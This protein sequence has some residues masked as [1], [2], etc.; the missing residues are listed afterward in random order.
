MTVDLAQL[1]QI[2]T[3]A[4]LHELGDEVDLVFRYGSFL[5]GNTHAYSDLDISYVPVHE[6]TGHHITVTVDDM[7][8]DLYPIRWSQLESMARFEN[9]SSTVLLTYQVI[10]QRSDTS[11]K[12]LHQL[13][14]QLR[15]S[16]Q[17]AARQ[18]MIGKAQAYF[19]RAGYSFYLLHQQAALENQLACLQQAQGIVST[20]AHSLAIVNQR[21]VDTR[22]PDQ[23]LALP[24]LPDDF[25]TTIAWVTS[26]I[27]PDELLAAC[28]ELLNSTHALLLSEQRQYSDHN[29]TYRAAF[30]AGYPELKGDLQHILLACERQD[31]F[32]LKRLL[33]SLY[34]ELSLAMTKAETGISYNNF[35]SLA[36]YEQD[37]VG[38]GFPPLLSYLETADFDELHRQTLAFDE[39]LQRFLV[40]H[41]AVLYSFAS[42]AELERYLASDNS[43]T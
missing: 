26:A 24:K 36:D 19:Q 13:A 10:Y 1:T 32:S 39:H 41:G 25:A 16:L 7:L 23:I 22:K 34:H 30:G 18:T 43:E 37:F 20:V 40:E 28:E 6:S 27:D 12:R 11:A 31:R 17:P 35:S 8:C 9:I 14:D 33:V 5:N 3:D 4:L 38:L 29:V 2:I 21:V 42:V 15:A